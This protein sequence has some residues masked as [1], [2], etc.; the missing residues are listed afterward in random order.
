MA[1]IR[2]AQ[3]FLRSGILLIEPAALRTPWFFGGE[4]RE[5]IEL[6]SAVIVD[7]DGPIEQHEHFYF[8]S[9][10]S[11]LERVRAAAAAPNAKAVILRFDSPGGIA[12]GCFE[13]AREVRR[14]CS[15]AGRQLHAFVEGSCNSAAY[16][17]ASVCDSIT[18]G[19]A[20]V[21]GS[22]GV[23][24]ARY[25]YTAANAADGLR[26]EI[27]TSGERKA[28]GHPDVAITDAELASTRATI[29]SIANVFFEHIAAHRAVLDVNAVASLKAAVLHG[30]AALAAGL[31]DEVGSINAVLAR[32]EAGGG[33]GTINMAATAWDKAKAAL[34]EA[35]KGS[36]P[37]AQAAK[38]ALAAMGGGGEGEG[39]EEKSEDKPEVTEP[40][41]PAAEPPAEEKDKA[42]APAVAPAASASG[43]ALTLESVMA[44]ALAAQADNAKLRAELKAREAVDERSKLIASRPNMAPEMREL[45]LKAPMN[46][47]RETIAKLPEEPINAELTTAPTRGDT[48]G[49]ARGQ[50]PSEKQKLDERMGLAERNVTAQSTPYKLVLGPKPKPAPGA[51]N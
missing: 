44:V 8:D 24:S 46:L 9:Y 35:A 4:E 14:I 37:N 45:L 11:I 13:A 36:D 27:I 5:N 20:G 26:V 2:Q 41:E 34:A 40:D 42:A 23:M 19:D 22:V 43:G 29:D 50:A 47:V 10:D 3:Q 39:E 12:A 16:A 49:A 6:G 17:L 30:P 32:I 25:D 28:D 33:G 1:R 31:A 48:Q 21:A 7:V 51:Q 38:K 15:E 18:L